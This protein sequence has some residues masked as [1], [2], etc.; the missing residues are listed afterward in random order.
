[1]VSYLRQFEPVLLCL[2]FALPLAAAV[3][4]G[5]ARLRLSRGQPARRAWSHSL[6]EVGA[7]VGTAPWLVM[8]M[9]PIALPA[10]TQ[11]WRLVPMRDIAMQLSGPPADAFVQITANLLVFSALGACAPV[12][13]AALARPARLLALGAGASLL[14]EV[15]QQVFGTGRVFSVDDILLNGLGCALGGLL[16]RPWWAGVTTSAPDRT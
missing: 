16:T 15:S 9:W 14:L 6:A 1:M 7:V 5:L 13:Y 8:G 11:Q 10:G 3:V 4:A 2:A 12:R